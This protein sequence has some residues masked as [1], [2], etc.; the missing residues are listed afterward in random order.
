[1][2]YLKITTILIFVAGTLLLSAGIALNSEESMQKIEK[3]TKINE[4]YTKNMSASA[5]MIFKNKENKSVSNSKTVLT[6]VE[7]K[8]SPASVIIPPR[9]EVYDG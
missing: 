9:V 5:S 6:D 3:T 2:R 8:T 7:M 1:M 4:L